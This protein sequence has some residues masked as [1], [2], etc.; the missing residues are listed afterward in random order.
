MSHSFGILSDEDAEH[1]PGL[2]FPA[3]IRISRYV[4][5]FQ[6]LDPLDK[7]PESPLTSRIR[8]IL[9]RIIHSYPT[10]YFEI[11]FVATPSRTSI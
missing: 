6:R 5:P 7:L 3:E 8:H 11:F 10:T 1:L 9:K 4:S 2:K